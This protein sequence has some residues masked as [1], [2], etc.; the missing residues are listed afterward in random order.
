MNFRFQDVLD[1]GSAGS[2]GATDHPVTR[3]RGRFKHFIPMLPRRG[4][5][6]VTHTFLYMYIHIYTYIYIYI[7]ISPGGL[8]IWEFSSALEFIARF[9]ERIR[10]RACVSRRRFV[11]TANCNTELLCRRVYNT[12]GE[13]SISKPRGDDPAVLFKYLRA[14]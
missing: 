10:V 9:N 5:R 14:S 4:F 1:R 2:T 13:K 11:A 8:R 6:I 12:R 7:Y 3:G